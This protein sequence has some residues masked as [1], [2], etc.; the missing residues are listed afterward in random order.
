MVEKLL[1]R[2]KKLQ[3]LAGNNPN[4]AE[5]HAAAAK[6]QALLFEH[7]LDMRDVE[8]HVLKGREE[9]YERTDTYL[10]ATAW[11]MKWKS[12]LYNGVS[13]HNF[14]HVVFHSGSTRLTMI[15]KR[16]NIEAVCYLSEYLIGAIER[17]SVSGSRHILTKKAMYQREFCFGA[18]SRVLARL[19]EERER[20]AQASGQSTA[21][22]VV[23]NRE[24]QQV[25]SAHFPHLHQSK[26]TISNRSGGYAAGRE[27]G[28]RI[29][30]PG[31]GVGQH[32]GQAQIA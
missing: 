18:M 1:D 29:S 6:V 24:L 4:E 5:S 8:G 23:S 10:K 16:S 25:V 14:C 21:L 19:R 13:K 27:A 12:T 31:R 30:M 26:P 22:V 2:I 28:G 32:G 7:N 17:L 9:A 20:A 15:G 3:A 11:T